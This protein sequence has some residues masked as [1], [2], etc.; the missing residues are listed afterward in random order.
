[1]QILRVA[2][3]SRPKSVAGAMAAILRDAQAV[4]IQAVGAGAVNQAVKA[5]AIARTFLA[6]HQLDLVAVPEFFE[7]PI[8]GE[9]RTAIRFR[10]EPRPAL[11]LE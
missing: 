5:M 9:T 3:A 10:V 6:P 7:I 8:D 2:A 11:A 4:E 1:L